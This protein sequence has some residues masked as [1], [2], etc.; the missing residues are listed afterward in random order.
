MPVELVY[1]P[2]LPDRGAALV[3]PQTLALPSTPRVRLWPFLAAVFTGTRTTVVSPAFQGPA[4]IDSVFYNPSEVPNVSL[5]GFSIFWALDETGAQNNGSGAVIPTGT[6]IFDAVSFASSQITQAD[7]VVQNIPLSV[8]SNGLRG[9]RYA[10]LGYPVS[11]EVPFF[12][13]V[14]VRSSGGAEQAIYGVIRVLEG[15]DLATYPF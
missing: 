3:A 4:I 13:K 1:P 5:G 7:E 14:S 2:T 11:S 15:V 9:P 12:L 10:R 8:P 6:P